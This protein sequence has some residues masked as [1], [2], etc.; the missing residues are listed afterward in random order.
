MSPL[1]AKISISRIRNFCHFS[2]VVIQF[3][4][5]AYQTLQ[6]L[7]EIEK[8]LLILKENF[9]KFFPPISISGP[10]H[11]WLCPPR[12]HPTESKQSKSTL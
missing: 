8:A 1:L 10:H 3:Q 4:F 11:A 12:S 2:Y 6:S 7:E 9:L 5:R